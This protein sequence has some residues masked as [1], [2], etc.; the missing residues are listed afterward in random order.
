M[1]EKTYASYKANVLTI[2][3]IIV[4]VMTPNNQGRTILFCY[5][6]RVQFL[7]LNYSLLKAHYDKR[8][9]PYLNILCVHSFRETF[10]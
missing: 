2:I 10:I 6:T 9:D 4:G 5:L 1:F 8:S 3:R 7:L